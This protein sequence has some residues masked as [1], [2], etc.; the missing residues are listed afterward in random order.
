MSY[1]TNFKLALSITI[2]LTLATGTMAQTKPNP[3]WPRTLTLGTASVG[4]T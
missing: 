3:N 4:G 2:G 1:A